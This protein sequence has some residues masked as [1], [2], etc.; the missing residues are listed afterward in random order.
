MNGP[1]PFLKLSILCLV[2][3]AF[4]RPLLA[5]HGVIREYAALAPKPD[6]VPLP[7]L[8]DTPLT[9][10]SITIGPDK[11]YYLTGSAVDAGGARLSLGQSFAMAIHRHAA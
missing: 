8:F 9:D 1:Y 5:Q 6:A 2:A 10:T 11:A 7:A 3:V 4:P